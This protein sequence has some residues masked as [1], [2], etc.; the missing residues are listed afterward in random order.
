MRK[1]GVLALKEVLVAFRDIGAIVT[2][3]VTPLVL[4]LAMAAAF[5][6]GGDTT[7][8]DIP[9]LLLNRDRGVLSGK[10]V[11]VLE[12]E[13][14]GDLLNVEHVTDEAQARS[15]I[16]A[17]EAAAL[18][19][20]PSN[21]SEKTF[22]LG[23]QIETI[24]GLE[25]TDFTGTTQLTEAEVMAI[26]SAY[27]RRQE[28]SSPGQPGIVEVYASPD[29]L[30]STAIVKGVVTQ[31]LEMLNIQVAGITEIVNRLM[32]G[33]GI[34]QVDDMSSSMPMGSQ[35]IQ[36]LPVHLE[37]TSSTGR[38]ISTLDYTAAS[39]AVMFLMFSVT[40]GG[41]SL[42]AERTGGT[43]PRLLI[44][45]TVP[46]TLIIGKMTGVILTGTLQVL[47]LW[48]ATSAIGAYWGPPLIVLGVIVAVVICA[49]GVGALIS[50]WARSPS[51]AG[52]LGT[53][54]TL[55]ASVLSGSF[56]A[57][58]GLPAWIQTVSLITPNA[59]AIEIFTRLQLGEHPST[60][61]PW[62]G[63]LIVLTFV[64]YTGAAVGFKRQFD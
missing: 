33:G 18:V 6:T 61:L 16:E 55:V 7:L 63:G 22:P 45:P 59:W 36:D 24:T 31:G 64:Y 19:I 37:I 5:G 2:M 44:S 11:D 26:A 46:L 43:L 53:G 35:D 23:A 10:L 39:I 14:V 41:R 60:I 38:R 62:V 20:I 58:F 48:G 13:D 40:S 29:R 51:Q 25:L 17:N 49:S 47:I 54:I 8:S 1:L 9:V 42:L 50:A 28:G 34:D 57:R 3:L 15:Q 27:E 32:G 56:F 4:T 21:F 30:I 52:A 12:S